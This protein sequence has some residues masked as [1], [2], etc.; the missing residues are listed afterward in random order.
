MKLIHCA[1]V[2]LDAPLESVFPPDTARAYRKEL[3]AAFASLVTLADKSGADALLIAGDLFDSKDTSERTV[4][5]VLE[6]FRAHPALSIF[7]LAGNHDGGGLSSRTDLPKNLFSFGKDWTY[8]HFGDVMIAGGTA[9]DPD[10]LALD[11]SATNIVLLHGQVGGSGTEYDISLQR[12]KGKHIDYLAL[13]HLHQYREL[14]LDTRGTACYSGCLMGRGFDEC[15]AKGY[16]LLETVNSRLTHRFV[17][18]AP[19]TLHELR[20]DISGC[21]SMLEIEDAVRQSA[22]AIPSTDLCRLVLTGIVEPDG[23]PDT[24]QLQAALSGRFLL[25]RIQDQTRLRLDP[26]AYAH[27]A[28]LK[29]ELIRQV[30]TSGLSDE[31]KERIIAYGLR[32]LRGEEPEL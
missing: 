30:L 1:D 9:P 28:S 19:R 29:G 15:G 21:R 24:V 17:P 27:D 11:P 7:Y 25:L 16:V 10:R 12:L 23:K 32:A 22:A 13:G 14:A 2:H 18:F 20:L 26:H 8:F 6:L 31:E 3:L 5:Y 4:Q